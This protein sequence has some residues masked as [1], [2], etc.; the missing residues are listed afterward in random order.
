MDEPFGYCLNTATIRGHGLGIVEQ[1]EL[2]AAAGY[3]GIE[4]WIDDIEAYRDAGG[5]LRDL[6]KRIA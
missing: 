6:R 1:V 3:G 5:S 4:P 2:A